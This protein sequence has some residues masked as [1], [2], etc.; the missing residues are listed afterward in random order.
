MTAFLTGVA[1][2]FGLALLLARLGGDAEPE[3][4]LFDGRES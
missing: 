2:G 3:W 4:L 1:T